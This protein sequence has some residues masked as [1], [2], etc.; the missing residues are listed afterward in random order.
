MS[1][2]TA[3]VAV[4]VYNALSVVRPCLASVVRWT[5][6]EQ[7]SLLIVNDGSD[8]HVTEELHRFAADHPGVEVLD[9]ER[10]LGFVR[11][12]NR[13]MAVTR[14]DYLVLLNSDTIVTPRWLDKIV[15]AME[16]D[17]RIAL[18]SP[19]S[20]FAPHMRIDMLPGHDYL[21]MAAL[22]EYL[23]ER[24][25]PDITTPEGFCLAIRT[26][27]L[28][29]IGYFD[30]VFDI[31]YGEES[32]MAMRANYLGYRT[33]C[34]DDTYVYHRGRGTFG[35]EKRSELVERNRQIFNV[36]WRHRYPNDFAEFRR[37]DPIGY[38]RSALTAYAPRDVVS[39]FP[40]RT[41]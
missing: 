19:I 12:C 6:L 29:D 32:D 40:H 25:Y 8:H 22:I 27:A 30:E 18:A 13:A 4:P 23:S 11:T 5:D 28:P 39:A 34:V 36:R 10:N 21:Q 9:N 31:G 7:F 26:S 35:G 15:A 41:P 37:R 38:L 16:G 24:A 20:N 14:T 1:R 3:T 2:P 33:V 17:S